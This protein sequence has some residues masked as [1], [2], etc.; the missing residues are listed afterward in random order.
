MVRIL[1]LLTP[2]AFALMVTL[3]AALTLCVL[4]VKAPVSDPAGIVMLAEEGSAREALL[5]D[6][7]TMILPGTAGSSSVT[8]PVA[9]APPVIG[10]GERATEATPIGRTV[11]DLL[12]LTPPKLAV[13]APPLSVVTASV[14]MV[15]LAFVLPSGTSTLDGTCA[16][17]LVVLRATDAPPGGAGTFSVTLPG[18]SAPPGTVLALRLSNCGWMIGSA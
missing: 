10:S 1:L 17:G 15:K 13:M 2:F 6:R 4:T 18:T 14:W 7:S 5:L 8:V 12:R 3:V 16:S 9:V 11:N